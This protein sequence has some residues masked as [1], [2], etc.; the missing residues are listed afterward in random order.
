MKAALALLGEGQFSLTKCLILVDEHTDP[1][2]FDA[3]ARVW[4]ERFNVASDVRI[5]TDT[6]YDSLDFTSDRTHHGSKLIVDLSHPG[7][8]AEGGE[9]DLS[10]WSARLGCSA[11][12]GG[13]I[14]VAQCQSNL[15]RLLLPE[16]LA[17]PELG[18]I[19]VVV[20]VDC[21]IDPADRV[22]MLWGWFTRFEPARDI[23]FAT[24]EL[25]GAIP[26]YGGRMGFDATFKAGY[27]EPLALDPTS[28]REAEKLWLK[29]FN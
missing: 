7:K 29:Y 21:D 23:R 14:L 15:A 20:L 1:R 6:A 26:S 3:V 25:R 13:G 22:R 28:E 2:D 9:P 5:I 11:T 10:R 8:E 16:L 18:R 19:R 24:T 27:P 12:Y 4:S 17:S